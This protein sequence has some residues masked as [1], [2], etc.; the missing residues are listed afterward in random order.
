[1]E[2]RRILRLHHEGKSKRFI[3]E[4][5]G[6]SRN[7]VTKYIDFYTI[8]G[9]SYDEVNA[10]PNDQLDN[11]FSPQAVNIP[12]RL[13]DLQKLFPVFDQKLKRPGMTKK[14][15]WTEYRA[16]HPDGYSITQFCHYYNIWKKTSSPSLHM[17]HQAGDKMFIDFTGQKMNIVDKKTRE[18]RT[19]EVF[20]A[21]L[22]A[23]QYT[24]VEATLS[25]KKEDFIKCCENALY[26]FGGVPEA[27]V[28]D[29]LKSAVVSANRYEPVLNEAFKDF[30]DHYQTIVYP[31]RVRKPKDKSLVELAV[32][33]IYGRIFAPLDKRVF[34]SLESLNSAIL[35]KLTEH[36]NRLLTGK[37]VSRK[38]LFEQME[39][40]ILKPLPSNRYQMKEFAMGTVYKNCHVYLARDKH[41][42]SVP[43]YY[44]RKKVKIVFTQSQVDIYYNYH[45][46]ASHQRDRTPYQYTTVLDHLP[47][48]HQHVLDQNPEKLINEADQIGTYTREIIIKILEEGS[49]PDQAFRSCSGII[50]LS[51]KVGAKRVERACQRALE[52]HQHTYTIV[53]NILEKGLDKLSEDGIDEELRLPDHENIRG[54]YNYK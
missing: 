27:I 9:L 8:S 54:K 47:E 12:E 17:N 1:M 15:L 40:N 7:T 23:S 53:K 22:G 28:P 50:R 16:N 31:T 42:Y 49:Y 19:V 26:Y 18:R 36:N 37:K 41:Y 29:N 13:A 51:Q 11:L 20:V 30:A 5:L 2:T 32:K 14:K 39:K 4:Y 25:Q 24:Y 45:Q 52:Y 6:I 46:I 21:I 38:M 35:E 33:I 48:K 10:M 34:Y 3:A 44:L 43:Y